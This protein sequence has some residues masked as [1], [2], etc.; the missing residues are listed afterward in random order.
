MAKAKER[1]TL[2]DV[3]NKRLVA[4]DAKKTVRQAVALMVREEVGSVLV[5]TGGRV[6]GILTE[7]DV[8]RAALAERE[9]F[10]NHVH[11]IMSSPLFTLP[12]TE[13]PHRALELMVQKGI[14]RVPVTLRGRVCG[15]VSQRDLVKWLLTRPT[16]TM[17]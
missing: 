12:A 2:A 10:D 6:V 16:A 1:A 4:I 17:K 11:A 9:V 5:T 13:S 7:R 15:F 14:R 3:M 8:L